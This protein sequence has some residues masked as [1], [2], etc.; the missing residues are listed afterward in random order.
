MKMGIANE[1]P[2]TGGEGGT[3]GASNRATEAPD[4]VSKVECNGS[5]VRAG[6]EGAARLTH[7]RSRPFGGMGGRKT[8][9]EW[10]L[11]YRLPSS[12]IARRAR[13]KVARWA[14]VGQPPATPRPCSV[15]PIFSRTA[16]TSLPPAAFDICLPN[17]VPL[18]DFH[19]TSSL[20]VVQLDSFGRRSSIPCC[21]R[22]WN[23]FNL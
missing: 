6:T 4:A 11:R 3:E 12:G 20:V 9:A 1:Y 14:S 15:V 22:L 2:A 17:A 18:E 10:F 16:D 5:R 8:R 23:I 19:R 21:R 7:A 13:Q